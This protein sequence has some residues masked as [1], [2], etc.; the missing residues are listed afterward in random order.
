MEED[1]KPV[2]QPQRRLNPHMQ[3]VNEK[4]E[5]VSTRPTS[6]WR[7]CIDYRRLNSVT[8]KDHFPLPFM[9]QVLERV[10]GHPFYCFL[11]GYSGY[12][13]IEI[14]LEDQ[15]KTTF[16]CPFGTFAY[17]RMPFGL[18]NA[19][20]NFPKISNS[21]SL[22]QLAMVH[23]SHKHLPFKV[24]LNLGLPFKSS[25]EITNGCLL[26]VQKLLTSVGNSRKSYLQV[27]SQR[28]ARGKLVHLLGRR[29]LALPSVGPSDFKAF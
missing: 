25:Q 7:V 10:S 29:S 3:E 11:D 2:R 18:C 13:Q 8:R 15:E 6:G 28:L 23:A 19:A 9:D 14:D 20:V 1:A 21:L 4:G 24:I 27:T 12:F 16:T 17:R 22:I 26:G 5:E